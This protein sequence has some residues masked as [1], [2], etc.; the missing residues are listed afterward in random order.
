M[1][2]RA[3]HGGIAAMESAMDDTAQLRVEVA[4]LR[5]R[6]DTLRNDLTDLVALHGQTL[7]ALAQLSG[8]APRARQDSG[9]G[10]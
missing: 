6:V 9:S 2:T 8:M 7:E 1:E 5:A 3:G 10:A 4:L